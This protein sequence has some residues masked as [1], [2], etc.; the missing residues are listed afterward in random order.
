MSKEFWKSDK[1]NKYEAFYDHAVDKLKGLDVNIHTFCPLPF[2]HVSTM[3][4]GEIKLC[5]R[6]QPPQDGPNPNVKDKDFNLKEYWQSEYMNEVRD[7]LIL[8]K[9]HFQ[10]KNCWKME[11][12]EIVSLRMNRLMDLMDNEIYRKNIEYY[13]RHREIEFKIPLIELKLSNVCNFKCRMCWPKDSSKWVTDWDK[14]KEFYSVGDKRYIEEIVDSNDLRKTRVMNLYE[15]DEE[16]VGNLIEL[17]E[18]VEELEF[19]GGEPLM[20]PIHY[21][22][23]DSIPHPENVT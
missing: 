10:C 15:K 22:V 17:M 9:K 14:V 20:D 16:F 11:D 18:H 23:L 1:T 3:P 8:G 5:C 4:H 2:T 7:D 13:I 19:A 12:N 21:R 6:A